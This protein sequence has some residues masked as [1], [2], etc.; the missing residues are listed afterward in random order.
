MTSPDYDLTGIRGAEVFRELPEGMRLQLIDGSVC[1]I[2]ANAG[3]G[4]WIIV[5]IIDDQNSPDRVG[6]EEPVFFAEVEK[7][8]NAS[9]EGSP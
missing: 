4:A 9:E 6:D 1:E 7:V 2:V 8:L 3:D 5:K